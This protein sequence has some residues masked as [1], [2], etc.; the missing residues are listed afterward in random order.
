MAG[1][2]SYTAL[3]LHGNGTDGSTS[4]IDNSV[5]AF[6]ATITGNTQIDTAQYKFG[7]ASILFDGSNDYVSFPDSPL[8][9]WGTQDL[10][11]D[12]WVR[13]NNLQNNTI[14][15]RVEGGNYTYLTFESGTNL[16]FRDL[17]SGIDFTRSVSVTTNIWYHIEVVRFGSTFYM[18]LDGIQQGTTYTNSSSFTAR[19]TP[20]DIGAM[21]QNASYKMNGWIDELRISVGIARHTSNFTP[22]TSEYTSDTLDLDETIELSDELNTIGTGYE[23]QVDIINLNDSVYFPFVRESEEISLSDSSNLNLTQYN[24]FQTHL[25]T[26]VYKSSKFLTDL[27]VNILGIKKFQ[28][29]LNLLYLTNKTFKTDLR[30]RY[31]AYTSVPIGSL[32]DF[33]VQLDGIELTDVDYTTLNLTFNLNSTP[34]TAEF[35]LARRHDNLDQKLNGSTSV[36]TNNNKVEV[37]D[38][39]YLLFTGYITELNPDSESDTIDV[40]AEDIRYKL[41]TE[42]IELEYGGQ[43]VQDEDDQN[44]YT[45][46]E[47][48]I[49]SAYSEIISAIGGLISSN[50]SLPFSGSFVPEYIKSYNTYASLLDE[51]IKN[52][53][54]ANWYIDASERLRF[55]KVEQGQVKELRLSSLTTH[56]HAYDVIVDNINLNRKVSSYAKSLNVKRGKYIKR[57]WARKEFSGWL[58]SVPAFL[59]SL[60]E[61]TIFCFQQWGETGR[62]FYVGINQTI[63]GYAS[64]SG[65]I[66]KPTMVVQW[67]NNDIEEDLIDITVGSGNPRKTIYLNSYGQ[68]EGNVKWDEQSKEVN[69]IQEAWLVYVTEETYDR[70]AFALDLANFE[71]NQTNKLSTS[72]QVTILLDAFKYYNVLFSDR[73]NLTNTIA[74]NIYKDNN[75]F[76]LNI[77]SYSINCAT[78]IVSLNLTNYGKSWYVKTAN[79]MTNYSA[80][81]LRYVLRKEAVAKFQQIP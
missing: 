61:K 1:I 18:F 8:W 36:I 73:I 9:D 50:D 2:D 81:T 10:T 12:C 69:D 54:N 11:I 80:P 75:G 45:K 79:F 55:T 77:D 29:H 25:N 44:L 28:T 32:N 35:K 76:P 74:N 17:E 39:T 53:A 19:T 71:L 67:Q 5:N 68:K 66:L 22:E 30:V 31:N 48:N 40:I 47:K 78:R 38:G 52:T 63:N 51:L 64:G 13:F 15:G 59:L 34:S 62:R 3:M 33:I 37:Y 46:F 56:R 20:I 41:A 49:A 42:S 4:I 27:R 6:I 70:R 60:V 21:T 72:A 65:W 26:L 16:R 58:N 57:T 14:L 43:W 24:K 23:S 7:G